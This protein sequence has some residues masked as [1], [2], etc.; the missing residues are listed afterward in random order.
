MSIPT[1]CLLAFWRNGGT[2]QA[3]DGELPEAVLVKFDDPR[4]GRLTHVTA[5]FGNCSVEAIEVK[6]ITAQF[7]GKNSSVLECIQVPLIMCWAATI[8]KVQG[9]SL[10]ATVIDSVHTCS[11]T[12][13]LTWLSDAYALSTLFTR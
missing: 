13:W 8:H 12:G 6:P 4:V 2:T 5:L 3:T 1:P 7:H 10:D 9:L 11:S